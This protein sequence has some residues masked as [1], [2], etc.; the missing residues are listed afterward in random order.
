MKEILTLRSPAEALV[1]LAGFEPVDT[2]RVGLAGADARVLAQALA[3]PCD[4]PL[5]TRGV[6][7]GYAVRSGDLAAAAPGHPVRLAVRGAVPMG[8][9]YEGEVGAG[10]A[11]GITTGGQLPAGADAVLTVESAR[12]A[13]P[14]V[15]ET[16]IAL[17]PDAN[18]IHPGEDFRRGEVLLPAGRRL[19]PQDA[20]LLAGLGIVEVEVRR[21]PRVGLLS[22]GDELVPPETAQLAPG[23]I[24]DVNQT[25]LAAQLRRAGA[26]PVPAGIAPDREEVLRGAITALWERCDAVL[27]SGGSSVGTHDLVERVLGS[28]P[29]AEPLFHGINVRPGKP[30][31]CVRLG[32]RPILG[33]PG[34]P[35]SSMVIF[36]VFVR[37]LLQRLAGETPRDPWPARRAAVMAVACPKTPGRDEYVRVALAPPAAPGQPW[38][39]T[40]VPGGSSAFASVVRA[41]GLVLVPANVDRLLGGE[42]VEVLLYG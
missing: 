41:D 27:V 34:H 2:E 5:F 23:T 37:P 7:D 20:G 21:R 39:V 36:D 1:L 22:T 6:M 42:E 9:A 25:V 29:G 11:V 33:L 40:P 35:V 15:I 32:G 8:G 18:V 19:R 30:T 14:A 17:R 3:A 31:L 4:W 28:L 24:R 13:A 12:P 10:E 26:D 16:E 38:R